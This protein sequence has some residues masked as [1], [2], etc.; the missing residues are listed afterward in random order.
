MAEKAKKSRIMKVTM[1]DDEFEKLDRGETHSD[2]GVRNSDGSLS[3]LPDIEE[4][5]EDDLP[6]REVVRTEIVYE[7]RYIEPAEP[8]GAEII[9]NALGDIIVG[10]ITDP[11]VQEMAGRLFKAF[12]E[13]KVKPRITRKINQ[14]KAVFRWN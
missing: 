5:S 4:I 9:G 14:W 2:K 6:T 3:A 8:T 10:V 12:F 11:E 1:D 7:D 13:Y